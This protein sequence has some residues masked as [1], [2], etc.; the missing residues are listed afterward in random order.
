MA[1]T[2]LQRGDD[3]PVPWPARRHDRSAPPIFM[4]NKYFEWSAKIGHGIY[5]G[6]AHLKAGAPGEIGLLQPL[7]PDHRHP[8]P[9]RADRRGAAGLDRMLKVRSGEVTCRRLCPAGERRPLLAPGGPDLDLH[10]PAVLPD[11]ALGPVPNGGCP[12][13][14]G[15]HD[16]RTCPHRH[17]P[18]L[19]AGLAALL[20][21]TGLTVAAAQF[22][23]G[24]L[25]VWVALAIASLK[26]GLV[27]AVFMH[28]KY[29][30][31]LFSWPAF[32]AGDPGD[33]HR[34]DLFR[35]ALPV[36]DRMNPN[37][38]QPP[39]RPS[40]PLFTSSSASAASCWSASPWPCV[41]LACA[42]T[43]RAI[44]SRS[45]RRITTSGW[46]SSGRCSRPCWSWSC[47]GTAGRTIWPCAAFPTRPC[48]SRPQH[49]CGRGTSPTPTARPLTSS[50]CRSASRSRS[51]W[52]PRMSCTAFSSLPSGSSATRCRG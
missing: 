6:S 50:M 27:I 24:A 36:A 26:A 32:G 49:A 30:G 11:F 2:A 17:L 3:A 34:L 7:L 21:L 12:S 48:R 38:R 19:S 25:N 20:A 22:H 47:S 40:I 44:R 16:R 51:S 10:F 46:R 23:F 35:R 43:A 52:S 14:R 31:P 28:M 9:A 33:L 18:N 8:R 42:T 39:P 41:W 15:Q 37:P 45:R 29:E 4:V 5:P 1:V 13:E